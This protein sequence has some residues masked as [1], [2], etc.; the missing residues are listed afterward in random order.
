MRWAG[1]WILL[2]G[3]KLLRNVSFIIL[4]VCTFSELIEGLSQ[5][6]GIVSLLSSIMWKADVEL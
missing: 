4:Q 5:L 1:V 2:A 6:K 3:V